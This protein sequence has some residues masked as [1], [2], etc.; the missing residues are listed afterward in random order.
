M[1]SCRRDPSWVGVMARR[2][3]LRWDGF[4]LAAGSRRELRLMCALCCPLGSS[5]HLHSR[6]ESFSS[7]VIQILM[8]K[9]EQISFAS[10]ESKLLVKA[11][12][13][14][15]NHAVLLKD[16]SRL[17]VVD[18][19]ITNHEYATVMENHMHYMLGRNLQAVSYL[20]GAGDR[21]YKDIDESLGIMNQVDLNAKLVLM[22][23]AVMDDE[24]VVGEE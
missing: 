9:G 18:H 16:M 22:L 4:R 11:D 15:S 3:C 19:I 8:H 23:S 24:M 5:D 7:A 6:C 2:V 14:Q 1:N 17:A 20:D 12:E 13:K 10:K 21:S